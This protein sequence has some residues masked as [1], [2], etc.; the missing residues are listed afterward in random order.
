[1]LIDLFHYIILR[2][3]VSLCL[4]NSGMSILHFDHF[5]LFY[6]Y[7]RC[8]NVSIIPFDSVN[9]HRRNKYYSTTPS[10]LIMTCRRWFETLYKTMTIQAEVGHISCIT[11]LYE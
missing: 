5:T 11:N 2:L 10:I 3:F 4:S 6:F 8:N 9:N 7:C 1:M